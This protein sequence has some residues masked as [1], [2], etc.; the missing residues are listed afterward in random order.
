MEA[1]TLL[2]A[3][4]LAFAVV[5]AFENKGA[6][7]EKSSDAVS[8]EQTTG[9]STPQFLPGI[10][11]IEGK[12]TE[13]TRTP[14]SA[15][16]ARYPDHP[17]RLWDFACEVFEPELE[18]IC[19]GGRGGFDPRSVVKRFREGM[20][21]FKTWPARSRDPT[22]T[23]V[24][25]AWDYEG[26]TIVALT[27]PTTYGHFAWVKSISI[28]SPDYQLKHQLRVGLPYSKFAEVFGRPQRG[29]VG[30]EGKSV[31]YNDSMQVSLTLDD[32][33]RVTEVIV[34]HGGSHGQ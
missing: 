31:Y 13:G 7:P 16:Y 3:L 19:G 17:Q 8:S 25:I 21:G 10:M 27:Y 32:E 15:E 14:E 33:K 23:L 12:A 29:S 2:L 11:V 34:S 6:A 22:I 4:V 20:K 26:L 9:A 30:E 1:H 24:G 28:T 18:T 5:H